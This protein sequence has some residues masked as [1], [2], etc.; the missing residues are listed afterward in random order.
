[1]SINMHG[2]GDSVSASLINKS[3]QTFANLVDSPQVKHFGLKSKDQLKTLT[4]GRQFRTLMIGLYDLQSYQQNQDVKKIIKEYPS[5]E[6]A[7]VDQQGKIVTS[8]RFTKKNGQWTAVGYGSTTEFI[9]LRQAQDSIPKT[10]LV[11]GNL[12]RIPALEISFIQVPSTF[13]PLEFICLQTRKDF[14]FYKGKRILASE[15]V[16][17]LAQLAKTMKDLPD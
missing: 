7:L 17:T 13:G 10:F 12:I 2:Q 9:E 3:I 14:N 5:R 8:V 4:G 11:K 6:V 1:M 16:W 15:A